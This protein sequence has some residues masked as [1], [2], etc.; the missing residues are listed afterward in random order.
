MPAPSRSAAGSSPVADVWEEPDR[1][2]VG[3]GVPGRRPVPPPH[4]R[5]ATSPSASRADGR[6]DEC[7]DARRAADR[8]RSYPHELSGGERQRVALA[9]ALATEPE[10]VLLDEPFASLDA[11]LRVV[12][13]RGGRGDPAGRGRQRPARDPRPAGG[14]VARRPGRGD[15]RRPGRAGGH[16]RGGLRPPGDAMG[17][18]VP[19]RRR[20]PAR[21]GGRRRRRVRARALPR[22]PCAA[23]ARST[24]SSGP[25]AWPSAPPRARRRRIGRSRPSARSRPRCVGRSFYGHDQVVRLELASGRRSAAGARA[26]ALAPGRRGA[27]LGRGPGQRAGGARERDRPSTRSRWTSARHRAPLGARRGPTV[28]V[29]AAV[30]RR[31]L[32]RLAAV[33]AALA[34]DPWAWLV[35]GREVGHLDLDTDGRAVVEAA[36][37]AGHDACSRRSAGAGAGAVARAGARRRACSRSWSRTGWPPGSPAPVAGVVAAGLLLLTPDGGPRFLRLV[38]EGHTRTGDRGA[39]RSGP[40]TATSTGATRRR[41]C[42]RPRSRSTDPRRGRSS[43]ST[44]CGLAARA[45]PPAARR[46]RPGRSCRCCGSAAT[47]GARAPAARRRRRPGR[48]RADSSDRLARRLG[49]DGEGRGDPGMGGGS[50]RRS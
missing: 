30:S 35:W 27:R 38:L 45:R 19:G 37:G 9:R 1:R 50:G 16:A 34:Y 18:R 6:V 29:V 12:A 11:G 44:P 40:S 43:P 49:A 25:R 31:R 24:S 7:L 5:R 28:A 21:H 4:G 17:G 32:G 36:A 20:R 13:A 14:P 39:L 48:R 42:W 15:A 41:W 26:R 2:R 10:V 22:R 33:P 8:A 46:A 3:H 47:G 23:T